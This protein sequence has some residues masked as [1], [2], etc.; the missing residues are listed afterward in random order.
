MDMKSFEQKESKPDQ[1]LLGKKKVE[2]ITHIRWLRYPMY[3]LSVCVHQHHSSTAAAIT[4]PYTW[5]Q[6][7]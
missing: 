4:A 2:M 7:Q 5:T 6:T 1:H 3:A